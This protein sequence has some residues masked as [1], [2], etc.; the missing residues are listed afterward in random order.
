[1]SPAGKCQMSR[2]SSYVFIQHP[3]E[4][5]VRD[6]L[7][8]KLAEVELPFFL[9]SNNASFITPA[10]LQVRCA[11]GGRIVHTVVAAATSGNQPWR[12]GAHAGT[13]GRIKE[14]CSQS[15]AKVASDDTRCWKVLFDGTL[16]LVT[17]KAP[18]AISST[19]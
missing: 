15:H 5:G 7:A 4:G 14:G 18:S 1:M 16:S 13:I 10:F 19:K 17:K 2:R 8:S 11:V 9:F 12:G 3:H 6:A